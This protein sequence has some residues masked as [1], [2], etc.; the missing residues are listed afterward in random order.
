MSSQA[1]RRSLLVAP[2]AMLEGRGMTYSITMKVVVIALC[3]AS[4][5]AWADPV[6]MLNEAGDIERAQHNC[7]NAVCAAMEVRAFYSKLLAQFARNPNCA[8][9]IMR[10]TNDKSDAAVTN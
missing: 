8:I 9:S 6:L 1:V 2:S 10:F 3:I 5:E 4:S 7:N